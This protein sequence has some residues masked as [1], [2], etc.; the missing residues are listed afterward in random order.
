MEKID[1]PTCGKD[2]SQHAEWQAYL[3]MEKFVKV[4]TNPVAYGSV[5]KIVCPMCKKDM[6]DHNGEQT[7]ECVNEFIKQVTSKSA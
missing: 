3:C 7:T 6:R 4:A 2:M 1:C 5:R